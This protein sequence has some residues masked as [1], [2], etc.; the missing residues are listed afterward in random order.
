MYVY[1]VEVH[2]KKTLLIISNT[3]ALLSS[4]N[5]IFSYYFLNLLVSED[6]DFTGTI[7]VW[8]ACV[9]TWGHDDFSK[10][11]TAKDHVWVGPYNKW[12][13]C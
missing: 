4:I 5:F 1:I 11:V 9:I 10:P 8:L 13:L 3:F 2:T 7:L 6:H 12:D